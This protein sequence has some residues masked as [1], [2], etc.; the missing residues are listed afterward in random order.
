[1][2][3]EWMLNLNDAYHYPRLFLW[4]F[5][6]GIHGLGMVLAKEWEQKGSQFF[7]NQVEKMLH[8]SKT[9]NGKHALENWGQ[10]SKNHRLWFTMSANLPIMGFTSNFESTNDNI[11]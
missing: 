9:Q 7:L 5:K 10:Y 8:A 4:L 6:V 11:E 1:M 3:S 2:D